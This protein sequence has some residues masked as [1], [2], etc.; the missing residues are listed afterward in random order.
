VPITVVSVEPIQGQIKR[1]V[2]IVSSLGE[3]AVG[4]YVLVRIADE[5]GRVGLGEASVTSVWSGETQAGAVALIREVLAPLVVGADPFDSEWIAR[6]LEKAAFGNSFARAALEMALLDLQG[7]TLKAPVYKLLGGR[8][9]P[10][11]PG[12][13]QYVLGGETGLRLKFV[14]GAEPATV[15]AERARTMVARGWRAIKVKVGRNPPAD[16]ERLRAV[17]DAI[18]PGI[19]LSVDANGGYTVDQAIWAAQQFEPAGVALFEQPTRRGDHQAMAEVRARSPMP[20]MADESV[21]T[22][23]DALEII[24][25]RAADVLSLYPG[26]HGG[27]RATLN[28]AAAAESAGIVCTIGSNLEREVATAAMAH[29]AAASPNVVCERFPGDLIGPLYFEKPLTSAPL[30]YG[31]DRLFV[32]EG[33]GLGVVL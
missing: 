15:A 4:N 23:H 32:P 26:K 20:V 9:R 25:H 11:G 1:E 21:F 14:I 18:G 10:A 8:D 16:V 13:M 29:V 27:I 12:R 30:R 6:R 5:M 17:R 24:R 22:M 3:H 19:F 31:A 28:I 33:P 2:A 7:Q